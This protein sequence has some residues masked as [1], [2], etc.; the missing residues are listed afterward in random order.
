MATE[1]V[2]TLVIGGGIAGLA[3]ATHL[4]LAGRTVRLVERNDYLGGGDPYP[5]R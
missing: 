3:C 2:E 1:D 4:K 5:F